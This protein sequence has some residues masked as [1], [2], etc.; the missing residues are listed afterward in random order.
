MPMRSVFAVA[1][2][3]CA[4][5]GPAMGQQGSVEYQSAEQRIDVSASVTDITKS[6]GPGESVHDDRDQMLTLPGQLQGE[7]SATA[8]SQGNAGTIVSIR[9]GSVDDSAMETRGRI[10]SSVNRG[11]GH[12]ATAGGAYTLTTQFTVDESTGAALNGYIDIGRASGGTGS[13]ATSQAFVTIVFFGFSPA[14]EP[15]FVSFSYSL[16]LEPSGLTRLDFSEFFDV[17][18]GGTYSLSVNAGNAATVDPST[19]PTEDLT[20]EWSCSLIVG[21][22]D[23]D[24]LLDKWEIH[25]IDTD[26]DGIPEIDLPAMGADPDHKDIFLEIDTLSGSTGIPASVLADVRT[27]FANA[28][29]SNPSGRTGITLHTIVDEPNLPPVVYI[30]PPDA[31]VAA[32]KSDWFGT[33][34]ERTGSRWLSEIRP[35]RLRVFRYCVWGGSQSG[36]SS[37]WGEIPGDD[38]IVT[39][40]PATFPNITDN[41]RA[42]TLMHELGHTLGLLHGGGDHIGH[43]PNYLS[44]MNY[45]FQFESTLSAIFNAWTLDF[46]REELPLVDEGALDEMIGFNASSAYANR[47]TVF[48]TTTTSPIHVEYDLLGQGVVDFDQDGVFSTGTVAADLTRVVG[49]LAPSPNQLLRGH[50]DWAS[51]N[52]RFAGSSNYGGGVSGGMTTANSGDELTG[53]DYA[54]LSVSLGGASPP[55]PA[56]LTGD[57]VLNFFDISAFL[58]AF[59]SQDP[60]ADFNGD[61]SF[62]FFDV[63]AFLSAFGL[64]CP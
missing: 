36:G 5:V 20:I 3:L 42:G 7:L 49:T 34:A 43:K 18:P 13:S 28:P 31:Q 21:D 45:S 29:V 9:S 4:G 37:G 60:V 56:D 25:G 63:S 26:G 14:P 58:S 64:G 57:G 51:V 10:A 33:S 46:S 27:A 8:A 55:C 6:G 35:A 24:G 1:M 15:S 22:R 53:D 39:L 50:D 41:D 52:L 19:A 61:G 2:C 12:G 62:N 48:N 32:L 59:A 40:D 16:G 30:S 54:A 23:G 44:V 11:S 38:F 17:H 47:Y